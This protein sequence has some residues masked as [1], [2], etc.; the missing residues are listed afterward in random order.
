MPCFDPR[1]GYR[2]K[3]V[4]PS[5]KRSIVFNVH[6]GFKD[7]PVEIPCGQCAGCRVQRS[8]EWA[9]RIHHE[10]QQHTYNSFL[11]LTYNEENLPADGGLRVKHFQD[12]MKR[13]RRAPDLNEYQGKFLM[14]SDRIRFFHCGEY[15]EQR[16]RPH[17][18]ACIFGLDFA[19]KIPWSN[20]RGNII[21]QSDSLNKLWEKGHCTIGNLTFESAAYV[22]RYITKKITGEMADLY[23]S[24]IDPDTGEILREI[25]PEYVTMSRRPGIGKNWFEKYKGDAFPDDFIVIKGRKFPVPKYYKAQLEKTDSVEFVKLRG[26]SLNRAWKAK[27]NP[28]NQPERLRVREEVF[29]S[30]VMKLKRGYESDS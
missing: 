27:D 12:F 1:K 26:R 5:G 6:E 22:A 25:K 30:K 16:A 3:T 21:Y 19:D 15:G 20:Q 17:Y 4:N 7:R 29:H 8:I 13:L 23:Y 2:S 11:T 24:E 18:H 9:I 14:D 28:H 10:S